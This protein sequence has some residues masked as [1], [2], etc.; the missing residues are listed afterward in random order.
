VTAETVRCVRCGLDLSVKAFRANPR[1]RDGVNSWCRACHVA[2]TR[3]WREEHREALNER[4]RQWW[5]E[6]RDE[7][8]TRRERLAAARLRDQV[9]RAER[10]LSQILSDKRSVGESGRAELTQSPSR[11]RGSSQPPGQLARNS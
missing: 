5:A 7:E 6:H 4:R 3:Q 8:R 11:S 2:R 10:E 1:K 9:M